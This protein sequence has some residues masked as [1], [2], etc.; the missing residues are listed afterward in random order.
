MNTGP[1]HDTSPCGVNITSD[2]VARSIV[3]LCASQAATLINY[4]SKFKWSS[5]DI[6]VTVTIGCPR[7]RKMSIVN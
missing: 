6:Y 5:G 1:T 4:C 3:V 7:G 2:Y